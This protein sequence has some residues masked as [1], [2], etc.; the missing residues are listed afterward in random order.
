MKVASIVPVHNIEYTFG[1]DYAML[2]AHLQD[3]YPARVAGDNCYRIIDNSLI[4]L[5]GA[6]DMTYL[7][8][9]AIKC[10]ANEIILPDVFCDREDTLKSV[11]N[12]LE[13]L[14]KTGCAERF[15]LMAVCQG[16]TAKEF[17]D[18]FARLVGI[19][20]IHCIGIP[21]VSE[22]LHVEGRPFF[23]Y[24]WEGCPKDIHLLGCWTSL[25]EI[26]KYKHPEAIRSID[27]CI[28]ALNSL[29]GRDVWAA[30]TRA[31]TI[32]LI[33]DYLYLP[34]YTRNIRQLRRGGWL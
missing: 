24:L 21:K 8:D 19:P 4:E 10:D 5:G 7:I 15:R 17:E 29:S 6:V 26:K 32:D 22:T 18:C 11:E 27:T 23:E 30:R 25:E 20:E 31:R 9:A 12:S 16:S 13:W 28:P 3:Y 34:T 2:L 14:N 33:N 1:G